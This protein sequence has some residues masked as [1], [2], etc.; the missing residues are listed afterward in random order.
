M[1]VEYLRDLDGVN[2]KLYEPE[3]LAVP[4]TAENSDPERA[5]YVK[6]EG[7]GVLTLDEGDTEQVNPFQHQES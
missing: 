2:V 1:V 4:A 7:E 5:E 6:G 3:R